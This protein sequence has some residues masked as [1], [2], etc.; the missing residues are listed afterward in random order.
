MIKQL[1]IFSLVICFTFAASCKG[2]KA[3]DGTTY[4]L[5]KLAGTTYSAKKLPDGLNSYDYDF[6]ICDDIGKCGDMDTS[7]LC[8]KWSEDGQASLGKFTDGPTGLANGA[9]VSIT[10]TDGEPLSPSRGQ[11][12]VP[13]TA[14]WTINCDQ[15]VKTI[16]LVTVNHAP[17][18]TEYKV[19]A[20]SMHACPHKGGSSSGGTIFLILLIVVAVVYFAGGIVFNKVRGND[21]ILPHQELWVGLP[22]LVKDG[23]GFITS[24]TCMRS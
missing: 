16:E 24:K 8:Q 7:S 20:K 23:V 9:G 14:V 18:S 5:S 10:Y 3:T 11:P 21:E 19:E 1:L 6:R 12:K 4:D 13:R 2:I 22:G 15:S 17:D